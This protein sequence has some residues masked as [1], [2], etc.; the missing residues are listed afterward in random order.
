MAN[1]ETQYLGLK[2]R[3][4]LIAGSSGFNQKIENL[5][6]LEKNGIGA[7]VLKSLFEEQIRFEYKK[8]MV[9]AQNHIAYPEADDYIRQYTMQN[10][11]EKYLSFI[12]EAKKA[13]SVPIIASVNC[14]SASEWVTFAK[15]IEEAGA[16]AIELNIFLLPSDETTTATSIEKQYTDIVDKVL[17]NTNLPV[18]VKLGSY[19]TDLSRFFVQLSWKK[20]KGLVL[21]NRPFSPDINIDDFKITATNMFSHDGEISTSLRWIALLSDKVQCDLCASTGIHDGAGVVKQILAGAASTQ[22]ASILYKKGPSE[23][24]NILSFV[25]QWMDKNQFASLNDFRG[26]MSY[27]SSANPAGFERVQFMKYFSGI[28]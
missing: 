6:E 16:D 27:K 18:A 2:L 9:D 21:F 28:E 7:I 4:P 19:F 10:E 20:I 8:Q 26:K 23:V 15:R 24:R 22:I 1:L 5:I 14:Y 17:E 25:E 11:V 3:N 12:A 13:V